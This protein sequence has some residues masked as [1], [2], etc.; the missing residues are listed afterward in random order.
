LS[1]IWLVGSGPSLKDTPMDLLIGEDVMVMNKYGRIS[2]YHKWNLVPTHYFKVDI[3]TVDKSHREEI[4]WAVERGCKLFLW[5]KLKDGFPAGHSMHDIIPE[6]VGDLPGATWIPR[7]KDSAY[8][9][10]NYKATQSWHFPTL[11]TAFGGM[12]TMIQL[13]VM[14]G[15]SEIYLLGCDLGY[16][17][18]V[19]RNHAIPNY[20]KDERDKSEMDNGNMLT[21]HKMAKR[22]SPIPIYNATVGG[23]LEV[24]PRV[25]MREILKGK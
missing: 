18:D 15:Y 5:D 2:D 6:G 3:N 21:L 19:N 13:G 1:R 8:Q 10:N 11:C 20:T 9:W 4:A 7:C 17:P 25:D 23:E 22:C 16:T 14:L 12:S 24:Y